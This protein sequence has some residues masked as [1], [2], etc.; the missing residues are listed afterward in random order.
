MTIA[1]TGPSIDTLIDSLEL[2]L[3]KIRKIIGQKKETVFMSGSV[4]DCAFVLLDVLECFGGLFKEYD[5]L[6]TV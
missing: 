4:S 6:I 1:T 5:G 2:L 3:T